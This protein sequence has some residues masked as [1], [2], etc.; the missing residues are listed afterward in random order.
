MGEAPAAEEIKGWV[1]SRLDEIGGATVGKI[2]AVYVDGGGGEAEWLL[3]RMG[4][5][6]RHALVPVRDAVAGV[7]HVWVPYDRE[8]I[9]ESPRVEPGEPLGVDRELELRSHYGI[10]R[11]DQLAT[12][13]PMEIASRP[14]DQPR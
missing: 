2:E 3:A 4:R 1:G 9:R 7:G 11:A 14:A 6:G 12:R 10:P 5:F 8:L 13:A